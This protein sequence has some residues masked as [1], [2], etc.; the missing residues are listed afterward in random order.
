MLDLDNHFGILRL[1]IIAVVDGLVAGIHCA[2]FMI[3]IEL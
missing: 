2:K 1:G 3:S